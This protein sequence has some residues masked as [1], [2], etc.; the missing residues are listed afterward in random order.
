MSPRIE[1]DRGNGKLELISITPIT[2]GITAELVTGLDDSG[3][4]V[5]LKSDAKSMTILRG[6]YSQ[7]GEK[8]MRTIPLEDGAGSTKVRKG[9]LRV[10]LYNCEKPKK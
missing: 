8:D 9:T 3:M 10:T 6:P 5:F 4:T 7:Q 2:P 1:L